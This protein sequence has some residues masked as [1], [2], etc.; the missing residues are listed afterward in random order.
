VDIRLP[1]LDGFQ[2]ARQILK[3]IPKTRIILTS[4]EDSA[5]YQE[6]AREA[7]GIAFLSKKSLSSDRIFELYH[8][9]EE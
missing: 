3:I 4:A 6:A 5:F 9:S 8:S 7:G 1:D 2:V